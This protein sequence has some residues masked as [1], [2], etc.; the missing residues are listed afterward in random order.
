MDWNKI[1]CFLVEDERCSQ[2]LSTGNQSISA[3]YFNGSCYSNTNS[4]MRL[5][6]AQTFEQFAAISPA[7]EFFE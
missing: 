1:N 6:Q 4:A 2:E 3:F 7:E 5:I